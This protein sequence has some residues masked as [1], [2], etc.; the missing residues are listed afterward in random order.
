ME[1]SMNA[2]DSREQL[3]CTLEWLAQQVREHRVADGW[4]VD[5]R[6]ESVE[7]PSGRFINHH[8]TGMFSYTIRFELDRSEAWARDELNA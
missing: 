4:E 3:A 2:E 1:A 8:P 6:A 5:A 7:V